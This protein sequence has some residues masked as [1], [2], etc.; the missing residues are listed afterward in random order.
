MAI[1]C[2][3][4]CVPPQRSPGCHDSCKQYIAEKA[5]YEEQKAKIKAIKERE[6]N[7]TTHSFNEIAY[8]NCK[9]HKRRG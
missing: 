7:L 9:R 3:K 1:K 5:E 4:D 2:C 8:A 6:P